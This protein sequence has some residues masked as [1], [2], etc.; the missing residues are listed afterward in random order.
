[1]SESPLKITPL[2]GLGEIGLN[3][4]IWEYADSAVMID[5]GLM[6]PDDHY[7]GVDVLIPH[8][9]AVRAAAHK[10]KAI[11]LTHGHE[12][13]IGAL[14]WILP[15]LKGIKIYG[16]RFTLALVK[17]KLEEYGLAK[18]VEFCAVQGG[19][20]MAVDDIIFHFIPVCH[21]IPEGLGLAV[22]TPV[23]RVIHSGDFKIDPEPLD[24]YKTDLAAFRDFAGPDGA[25]LL[26]ADSTNVLRDGR[27]ITE[28]RVR[29][30]LR[31]VF[32]QARDRIVV[33]LFSSHIQRIQEVMDLAEEYGRAVVISGK[34]LASNIDI[35]SS[36]GLCKLPKD[37]HNAYF[38]IPD[39]PGNRMVLIVT[40]A[41]GEPLSALAR[42]VFGGHKQLAIMQGDTVI[43]SSRVIPGNARPIS[44]M[45]NEIY[46]LGGEVYY[47]SSHPVHA[48][49]HAHRDELAEMLEAVRPRLFIPIHGEYQHLVMHGR[50]AQEHGVKP[51]NVI[52]LEDGKPIAIYRDHFE[53]LAPVPV[54][55]T[56]VDGKGVGDVGASILKERRI[57]GD[58]GIVIVSL[59]L[60]EDTLE[61]LQ[62]PE[63]VSCGFIYGQYLS[64]ILEDAK[65]L[66]LDELE[67]K[68]PPAKM[69]ENMR[70]SLRN[71][72]RH[73]I[74]RDPVVIPI[75]N[76]V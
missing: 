11:I 58:E 2:G 37:F 33:T 55:Y 3:C 66:V 13:H 26:L 31:R 5:C 44:R 32:E 50:L 74:K 48:S 67:A 27:S 34:S 10:L 64:H 75:I 53:L 56:L 65:C 61:P 30:S 12:D 6:F 4:Q 29:E 15:E 22:E 28:A 36:L 8:F 23:G 69:R 18:S 72:F 49:G 73:V 43:M 40:G 62:A 76:L 57:M 24:G 25:A 41:Q 54:D 9:Q 68:Q 35:A 52:T 16:S 71:F 42:M 38:G 20:A 39:L 47:E 70:A 17:N 51:D 46:R 19:D 45:I 14:P 21:S 1:M 60:D 59:V 63:I 7:L